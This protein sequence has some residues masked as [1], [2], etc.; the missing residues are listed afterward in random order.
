MAWQNSGKDGDNVRRLYADHPCM[1]Q[2]VIRGDTVFLS[3]QTHPSA[4]GEREDVAVGDDDE[5]DTVV[6]VQTR[7]ILE[8]ID[9]LLAEAGTDKSHLLTAN[10]WLKDIRADLDAMNA[11]WSHW[12]DPDHKPVRATV[13]AALC[14][15]EMLVE[16]QVTAALPADA[17]SS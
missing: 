6:A 3:G 4:L 13:Q 16:I 14:S 11:V 7:A 2:I 9:R 8:R 15:E 10:V 12:V 17:A 5:Y 1:S